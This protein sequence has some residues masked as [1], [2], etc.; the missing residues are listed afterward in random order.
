MNLRSVSKARPASKTCQACAVAGVW[1][2]SR[3]FCAAPI[4][5][6][7]AC[8]SFL[9]IHFTENSGYLNLRVQKK[10]RTPSAWNS[11]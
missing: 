9:A 11:V 1:V 6:G 3:R 4:N 10:L 5:F 7:R 8:F 2:L